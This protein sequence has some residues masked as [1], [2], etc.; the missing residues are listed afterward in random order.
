LVGRKR[1]DSR[2]ALSPAPVS[3]FFAETELGELTFHILKSRGTVCRLE[4]T[5]P[6]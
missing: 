2:A 5:A 1:D 6:S 3:R 4:A